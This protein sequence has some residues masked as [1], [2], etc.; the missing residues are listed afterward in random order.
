ML[1]QVDS[2][3]A[4]Q[5]IEP[6]GLDVRAVFTSPL[7]RA[8]Q[9][10]AMLFPDRQAIVIP[11][12]AEITLGEWDGL[13]WNEIETRWPALAMAKLADWYGIRAPEGEAWCEFEE[14]VRIA[15]SIVVSSESPCAV[16][17]HAAVNH[18]LYRFAT[19]AEPLKQQEYCEVTS[20]E[21]F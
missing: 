14:R 9:T 15:W 8:S 6:S 20:V 3:L 18:L 2:P 12:L 13:S 16:V 19:G 10:A 11:Q 1:G 5:S 4:P 17:A 21:I 7:Q